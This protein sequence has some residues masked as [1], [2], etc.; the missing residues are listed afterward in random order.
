MG[1]LDSKFPLQYAP[2][3]QEYDFIGSLSDLEFKIILLYLIAHCVK[4]ITV[5]PQEIYNKRI[6]DFRC[7]EYTSIL[8]QRC[9][10][11]IKDNHII[12]CN[13]NYRQIFLLTLF[14]I[15]L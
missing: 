1:K 9:L 4:K 6:K 7:A 12:I 3:S 15:L 14:V 8:Y 2:G 13:K 5:T 11:P 10:Y